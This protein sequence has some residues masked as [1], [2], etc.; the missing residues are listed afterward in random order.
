MLELIAKDTPRT[1]PT[2]PKSN[3]LSFW[4]FRRHWRT[5]VLCLFLY[6]LIVPRFLPDQS[7]TGVDRWI[8]R[9]T[10]LNSVWF[11]FDV[12]KVLDLNWMIVWRPKSYIVGWGGSFG[13]TPQCMVGNAHTWQG[14]RIHSGLTYLGKWKAEVTKQLFLRSQTVWHPLV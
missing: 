2:S 3:I 4:Y 1:Q 14:A 10:Y 9:L 5:L 8:E 6:E 13:E 7:S 12:W 11:R